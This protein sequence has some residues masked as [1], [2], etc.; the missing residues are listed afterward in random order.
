MEPIDCGAGR[1]SPQTDDDG[2]TVCLD[3]RRVLRVGPLG[4]NGFNAHGER[5]GFVS[6]LACVEDDI[7]ETHEELAADAVSFRAS[8]TRSAVRAKHR[9]ARQDKAWLRESA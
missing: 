6:A 4:I 5:I 9:W 3:C 2:D 7:A 8:L 1:H